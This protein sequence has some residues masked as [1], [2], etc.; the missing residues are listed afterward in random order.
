[1]IYA[2]VPASE[3]DPRSVRA[4]DTALKIA[5]LLAIIYCA[6]FY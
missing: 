1:M 2:I 6:G 5:Y 4:T 3:A